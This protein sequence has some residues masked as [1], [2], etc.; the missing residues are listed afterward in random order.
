VFN[1]PPEDTFECRCWGVKVDPGEVEGVLARLRKENPSAIIQVFGAGSVPNAAAVEMVAAQTLTAA[2]SGSTL[3]EKPELD[4]LLRRAGTRQIGEA[5]KRVGYKSGGKRLFI[6][7]ATMGKA[8]AMK[9]FSNTL[10][11]DRRFKEV[12]KKK[13]GKLD[14]QMV[15]RAALLAARL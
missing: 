6:V 8:A 9:R 14:L 12:A 4:L 15:E 1:M 11:T 7:A 3:A 5:F 13:L 10:S 2:K